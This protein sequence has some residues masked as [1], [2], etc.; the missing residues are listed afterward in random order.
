MS[1]GEGAAHVA[2]Y[3]EKFAAE[4]AVER[5]KGVRAIAEKIEV[6]YP[7]HKKTVDD[8]IAERAARF[9]WNVQVSKDSVKVKVKKGWVTRTGTVDWQFQRV[10]AESAFG[11]FPGSSVCRTSLR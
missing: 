1:S 6:R 2:S 10:A 3:V 4:R 9:G 11:N 5:I 8:E 7:G